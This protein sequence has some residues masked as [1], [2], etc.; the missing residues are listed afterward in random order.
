MNKLSLHHFYANANCKIRS[1]LSPQP[2]QTC[3]ITALLHFVEDAQD[4]QAF[5]GESQRNGLQFQV[6]NRSVSLRLSAAA[7]VCHRRL[8]EIHSG[9]SG[10]ICNSAFSDRLPETLIL[11]WRTEKNHLFLSTSGRDSE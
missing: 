9:M 6:I 2:A 1:Q 4:A 3:S 8:W 7:H 5:L 10:F 11:L